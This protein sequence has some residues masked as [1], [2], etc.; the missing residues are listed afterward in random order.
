MLA[1][2]RWPL[3]QVLLYMKLHENN[4]ERIKWEIAETIHDSSKVRFHVE[5][6]TRINGLTFG[7][8]KFY[9]ALYGKINHGPINLSC[10]WC[11]I[12]PK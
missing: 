8:P 2:Y 4:Q 11:E 9:I 10:N 12:G 3:K 1:S 5:L 6:N 7:I